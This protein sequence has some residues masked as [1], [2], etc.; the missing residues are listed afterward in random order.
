[1]QAR[2]YFTKVDITENYFETYL[3]VYSEEYLFIA[4]YRVAFMYIAL[5][6]THER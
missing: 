6:F 1:M 2:E 5:I 3:E 4:L